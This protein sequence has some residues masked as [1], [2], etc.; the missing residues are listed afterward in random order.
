MRGCR[1]TRFQLDRIWRLATEDFP[2]S[3]HKSITTKRWAGEVETEI[4]AKSIDELLAGV[5]K[6]TIAGDPN[7][8]DNLVLWIS[9]LYPD[10]DRSIRI[11]LDCIHRRF[12]LDEVSV[13]VSG[14]DPGWAR[15]RAAGLKDL[16]AE[17]QAPWWTGRGV[18][19]YKLFN[20]SLILSVAV[21]NLVNFV[22]RPHLSLTVSLLVAVAI[23]A[24]LI[25]GSLYAGTILNRRYRMKLLLTQD[26]SNRSI[27]KIGAATLVVTI[28]GVVVGIAA[29]LVAHS[30]TIHPHG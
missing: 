3:A 8:L 15:G 23:Y 2:E 30:D 26:T 4:K 1:I 21:A 28:I 11:S 16:F 17:V 19:R 29:I 9:T 22:I 18:I 25:G 7:R 12:P 20:A 5:Q 6:S 14:T 10:E 27:D 24:I 13:S